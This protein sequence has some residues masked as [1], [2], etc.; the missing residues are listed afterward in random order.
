MRSQPVDLA[1]KSAVILS[2]LCMLHCILTPFLA[3]II[4]YVAL[5]SVLEQETTH[6]WLLLC[7]T[8]ISLF[9][10]IRGYQKHGH[11]PTLLLTIAGLLLL[12]VA[13]TIGHDIFGHTGEVIVTL[14]GSCLLILGHIKNAQHRKLRM[15]GDLNV[16]AL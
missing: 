10:I 2:F 11:F 14:I 13:A 1:D 15:V 6:I 7:V 3:I 5:V 16:N 12:V 4:P 8:P 9:A